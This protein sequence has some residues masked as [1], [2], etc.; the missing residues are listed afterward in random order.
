[1]KTSTYK[2]YFLKLCFHQTNLLQILEVFPYLYISIVLKNILCS[3]WG[4]NGVGCASE[5]PKS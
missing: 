4:L 2:K 1:M 3:I 5:L